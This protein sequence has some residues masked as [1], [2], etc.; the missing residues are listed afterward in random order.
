MVYKGQ[1]TFRIIADEDKAFLRDVY[2][3][4][5]AW[6]LAHTTWSEKE[7]REFLDKQ[8]D[9]QTIG[10]QQS[11]IGAI[12]RIIQ[13][14]GVDIGRL[15]VLRTDELLRI[16]DLSI[17]TDYRGRGIG[18][19]ILKSLINEAVGGKVPVKLSVERGNPAINLYKRLDFKPVAM[20]ANHIEM[21][22]Q[23]DLRPREI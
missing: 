1:V 11:F 21:I 3:D 5:R 8:F 23:P 16:I 22:W 10:Y 20:N 14:D 18:A 6:E 15:I 4:S 17:M 12:H 7:F 19:D 13:L 2:A 9:L